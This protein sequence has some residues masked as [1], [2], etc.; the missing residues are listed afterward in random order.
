MN[1]EFGIITNVKSEVGSDGKKS[2]YGE[3]KN[4]YVKRI[5]NSSIPQDKMLL[6]IQTASAGPQVEYRDTFELRDGSINRKATVTMDAT[7]NSLCYVGEL[8]DYGN[9]VEIQEVKHIYDNG[10]EKTIYT[11]KIRLHFQ[12]SDMHR[13]S[14]RYNIYL[15]DVFVGVS[16]FY[17]GWQYNNPEEDWSMEELV[18]STVVNKVTFDKIG[19]DFD[20][21]T[22][23]EMRLRL[24]QSCNWIESIDVL[25]I[26]EGYP[27]GEGRGP[28]F[29]EAKVMYNGKTEIFDNHNKKNNI[30]IIDEKITTDMEVWFRIPEYSQVFK[31]KMSMNVQRSI[32]C[33]NVDYLHVGF[34]QYATQHINDRD[35]YIKFKL[36]L[37]DLI[38]FA[39]VFM[40]GLDYLS[41][42]GCGTDMLYDYKDEDGLVY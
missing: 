28:L 33:N 9:K 40:D 11:I 35:H 1:I 4:L 32:S 13:S 25:R 17:N 10:V 41:V 7:N 18:L 37:R 2:V 20:G 23:S 8:D 26:S 16:E 30:I 42:W 34:P 6:F 24:R 3:F 38:H 29:S 27:D 31:Y 5:L 22:L 14:L 21:K 15:N 39:N 19:L 36:P 12:T